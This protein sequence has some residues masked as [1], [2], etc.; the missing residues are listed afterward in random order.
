MERLETASS[1]I[2]GNRNLLLGMEEV[3]KQNPKDEKKRMVTWSSEKNNRIIQRYTPIYNN[4]NRKKMRVR[5][6]TLYN[7]QPVV[8]CA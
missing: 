7:D 4:S 3:K 2:S 8:R 5:C 1:V 6:A